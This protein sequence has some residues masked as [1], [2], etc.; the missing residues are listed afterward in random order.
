MTA[1]PLKG[2]KPGVG[3]RLEINGNLYRVIYT[4][5]GAK[6]HRFTAE[7]VREYEQPKNGR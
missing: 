4:K 6:P 7:L 5:P 3:T 1:E 2:Q